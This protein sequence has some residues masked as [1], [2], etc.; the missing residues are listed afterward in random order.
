MYKHL[1]KIF[2]VASLSAVSS[3][4]LAGIYISG[5][6]SQQS[7]SNVASSSMSSSY[8]FALGYDLLPKQ[9][10]FSVM[11]EVG[12]R[13]LGNFTTN[14]SNAVSVGNAYDV[15]GGARVRIPYIGDIFAKGGVMRT[16]GTVSGGN[17]LTR[18]L[19]VSSIGLEYMGIPY[20]SVFTEYFHAY[21]STPTVTNGNLS[22]LPA[23]NAVVMGLA[24][25]F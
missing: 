12:M 16:S 23:M 7:L 13:N 21:G 1:C 14:D 24:L 4:S 15:M 3:A 9:S 5:G 18:D 17:T 22:A 19:P 20:L 8:A 6:W 25:T 2:F 11:A 10:P